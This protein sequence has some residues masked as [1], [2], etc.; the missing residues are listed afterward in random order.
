MGNFYNVN[1][2]Y[3]VIRTGHLSSR[4]SPSHSPLMLLEFVGTEGIKGHLLTCI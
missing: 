3:G 1:E 4:L 2:R